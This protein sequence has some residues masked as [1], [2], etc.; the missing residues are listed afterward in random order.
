MNEWIFPDEQ[1]VLIETLD[2][3]QT[4]KDIPEKYKTCEWFNF[5]LVHI[6]LFIQVVQSTAE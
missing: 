1:S 2:D 3:L 5:K 4:E 6:S